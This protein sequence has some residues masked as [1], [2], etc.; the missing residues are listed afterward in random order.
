[1]EK[2]ILPHGVGFF[3]LPSI[4]ERMRKLVDVRHKVPEHAVIDPDA[5]LQ[6]H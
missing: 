6:I 4:Q 1:M 3:I 5:N 2:H